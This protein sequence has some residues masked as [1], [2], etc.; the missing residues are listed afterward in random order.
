MI[1]KAL[2]LAGIMAFGT[3]SSACAQYPYYRYHVYHPPVVVVPSVPVVPYIV[4]PPP[5]YVSPPPIVQVNPYCTAYGQTQ[6]QQPMTGQWGFY[7]NCLMS[8]GT[9]V[10]L[11]PWQPY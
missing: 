4:V 1:K 11:G 8:N 3:I 2:V 10:I 7:P 5:V 9:M 6:T